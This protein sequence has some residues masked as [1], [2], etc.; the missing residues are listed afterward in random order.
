MSL[1]VF[2]RDNILF[3]FSNIKFLF[4]SSEYGSGVDVCGYKKWLIDL[5]SLKHNNANLFRIHI[6]YL[7]L[8]YVNNNLLKW[9]Y[10]EGSV[11]IWGQK[12]GLQEGTDYILKCVLLWLELAMWRF[13]QSGQI[14][15]N[16]KHLR[17]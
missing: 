2:H 16:I 4:L 12:V 8:W 14:T 11:H 5:D 6:L 9:L 13:S 10:S 17:I 7:K 15:D 1:N 3:L